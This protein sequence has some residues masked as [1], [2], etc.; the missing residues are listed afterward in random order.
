[1]KDRETG[2]AVPAKTV[3][4]LVVYRQLLQAMQVR[5][6]S[7]VFS[8][9]LAELAGNT[10]TQVRRD[11]MVVG[12]AGN[13]RSGYRA[14]DALRAIDALLEPPEG[15]PMAIAGVGNLGRAMLGYFSLLTPRFRVVAAFDSDVSK[16]G[17]TICG[18]RVIHV[19]DITKTL[20]ESGVQLG[21]ITVPA[22]HAQGIAD[23]FVMAGVRG[24]VNFAPVPLRVPAGVRLE[25]MHITAVFEKVAY[26]ARHNALGEQA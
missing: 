19:R 12:C 20:A 16:V 17:R 23:V 26:F 15:I 1:M 5:G 4:R 24:I 7:H 11:L 6:K 2:Q 13:T 21:V 3:E 10:A 18:H 22:D 9:D 14:D 25:N 8:M